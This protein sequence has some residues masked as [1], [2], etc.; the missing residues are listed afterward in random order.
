[1]EKETSRPAARPENFQHL[2]KRM[3]DVHIEEEEI[4]SK[5]ETVTTVGLVGTGGIGKTTLA[6]AVFNI[7]SP[8]LDYTCFVSDV[9]LIKG[10][11]DD[12]KDEL[13]KRL[14]FQGRRLEGSATGLS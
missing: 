14:H 4:V 3:T 13:W 7:L 8:K 9:K 6:K 1:M 12:V 5:L 2:P 11:Q 10:R